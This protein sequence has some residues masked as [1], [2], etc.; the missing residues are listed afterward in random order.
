VVKGNVTGH[1]A[2]GFYEIVLEEIT[3]ELRADI[4]YHQVYAHNKQGVVSG[5]QKWH[6]YNGSLKRG[7]M[8]SI[9][10]FDALI[11]SELF[12]EY[13]IDDWKF[14]PLNEL[15]KNF[16]QMNARYRIG[17]GEG[18]SIVKPWSSCV[19]DSHNALYAALKGFFKLIS[20][21]SKLNS[22][23]SNN[24][25]D[26]NVIRFKSLQNYAKNIERRITFMGIAQRD[27][28]INAENPAG[29]RKA[30]KIGG[31]LS[32]LLSWKTSY[33]RSGFDN[34]LKSSIDSNI[35]GLWL[36]RNSMIGGYQNSETKPLAPSTPF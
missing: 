10:I 11:S 28:R 7:W 32:S 19:Q 21:N 16:S 26:P 12:N 33:P 24:P 4:E 30:S 5:A 6:T 9:P 25:N 22:W 8:Y 31:A 17:G 2:F 34:F 14:S 20:E 3:G 15:E 1:F 18:I 29:H 36:L 23:M 35:D 27:W 13:Q